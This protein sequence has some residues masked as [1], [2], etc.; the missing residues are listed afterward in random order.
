E[1]RRARDA[2]EQATRFQTRLLTHVV[3][4]L[5]EPLEAMLA[6]GGDDP[7]AVLTEVHGDAARLLH[8]SADLLDLARSGAGDLVLD[9]RLLDPLPL[10]RRACAE[11]A[12]G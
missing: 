2:A 12:A 3:A 6:R 8:L 11:A 9:R 1:V 7:E 5:R 10:L 4:E